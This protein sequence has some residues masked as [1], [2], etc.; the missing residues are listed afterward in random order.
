MVLSRLERS[1]LLASR[2]PLLSPPG[3]GSDGDGARGNGESSGKNA[4][5]GGT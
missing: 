4:N 2:G 3:D 5:S 1:L